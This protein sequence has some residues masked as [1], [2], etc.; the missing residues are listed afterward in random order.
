MND[1][2]WGLTF[3]EKK[4]HIFSI[5]PLSLITCTCMFSICQALFDSSKRL[6]S[7]DSLIL[8]PSKMQKYMYNVYDI[9]WIVHVSFNMIG[10]SSKC[11]HG[12][13]STG[14][15]HKA[16]QN[17]LCLWLEW[18]AFTS[19]FYYVW[20]HLF[21]NRIIQRNLALTTNLIQNLGRCKFK[22]D[23]EYSYC[24]AL[25]GWTVLIEAFNNFFSKSLCF[26]F[27]NIHC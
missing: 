10:W 23:Q 8:K 2:L 5:F 15:F 4:S 6:K 3:G 11:N 18:L 21:G 17:C 9:C 27:N 14:H 12:W 7:P 20:G 25:H 22:M 16:C 24:S 13:P 19:C 1:N 26:C